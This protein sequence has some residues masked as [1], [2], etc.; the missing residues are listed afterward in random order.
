M[1]ALTQTW[2]SFFPFLFPE[3]HPLSDSD[4]TTDILQHLVVMKMLVHMALHGTL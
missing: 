4:L 3:I 2:V 1:A